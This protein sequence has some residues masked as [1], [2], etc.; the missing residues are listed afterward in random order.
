MR[1][2]TGDPG[3][4][5]HAFLSCVEAGFSAHHAMLDAAVLLDARRPGSPP[6]PIVGVHAVPGQPGF[7]DWPNPDGS[8]GGFRP[9]GA[10]GAEGLPNSPFGPDFPPLDGLSARRVGQAWLVVTGGTGS[11]QRISALHQLAVGPIDLRAPRCLSPLQRAH[12]AGSVIDRSPGCAKSQNSNPRR[13]PPQRTSGPARR[14]APW[15]RASTTRTGRSTSCC[16]SA[17][18]RSNTDR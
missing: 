11:E 7:F 5:G 4:I 17:D 13:S 3:I 15:R 9:S 1:S 2:I 18:V 8:P 12:G 10:S 6:A 14:P 16:Q